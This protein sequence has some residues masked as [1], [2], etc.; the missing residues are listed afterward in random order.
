MFQCSGAATCPAQLTT[1][2]SKLQRDVTQLKYDRRQRNVTGKAT[3]DILLKYT[4]FR[5]NTEAVFL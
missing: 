5:D 4:Q 1:D 2:I 3:N